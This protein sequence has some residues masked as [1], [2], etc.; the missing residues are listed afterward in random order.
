[1]KNKGAIC[2]LFV[3]LIRRTACTR[4]QFSGCSSTTNAH[5]ETGR[6]AVCCQ[7]L[8]L[9]A[10]S[11]RS[12]PSV[13]VGELFKK[14]GL[15]LNT[16][17]YT[18]THTHTHMYTLFN[19]AQWRKAAYPRMTEWEETINCKESGM[20]LL[21]PVLRYCPR[22]SSEVLIKI[23]KIL[24]TFSWYPWNLWNIVH[25]HY[26]QSQ[27]TPVSGLWLLKSFTPKMEATGHSETSLFATT[28]GVTSQERGMFGV[29]TVPGRR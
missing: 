17:V 9:G 16:G 23:T 5:S 28:L 3:G 26:Q 11:S 12:A 6:M 4:A 29:K 1:M 25:K 20:K 10:L 8:P 2:L 15:F 22:I 13:L 27:V 19:H 24:N 14:F 18:H 21:W 7:N